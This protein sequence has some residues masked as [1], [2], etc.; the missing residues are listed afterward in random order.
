M[1][2]QTGFERSLKRKKTIVIDEKTPLL[3]L[4]GPIFFELFLNVL[5]NNIDTLMLSHYNEYAVGAVGN[6]NNIMFM[7]NI[8]FNV[9]ATATSVVVAQ[10]L[11]AKKFHKMNMIYTLAFVVNLVFGVTLSGLFCLSNPLI[12]GF[13]NVS[14]EMRP[15]AMTYIYIVGG[16]GFLIAVYSVM[17]QI[18]RC[19][20]YPKIGMWITLA[21]NVVNIGGNYL[22]LYGPLAYLDMGVAGVAISTVA[23]RFIAVIAVFIFFY[24]AKIGKISFRLLRPF[25]KKLLFKMVK[26]GLPTAGE[27][28]TY[29]LY[30]TTMLSFINTMGN[31]SVNARTYCNTLIAFA[32]I[33]SNA[34][35]MATQIIT[36][37]LVGA[38]KSEEA[39]KR[40]FKTLQT[41]LPITIALASTNALICRY[42]LQLF[43]DNQNIIA[44]GQMIMLVD[45]FVEIGRCLNMTFV[46]SLKAAGAYIFP[47]LMGL[48]CNWGLGLSTGYIVGVAL[49]VGVAGIFVGTATDECI[50][51]LIV[52]YYWYKKKWFG[53]SVVDKKE[54]ID[55]D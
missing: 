19:N 50:R 42:T 52:M 8:F 17:L 11:G 4:A 54:T 12:M 31:D 30:Q 7:M 55:Y 24:A 38:G 29:N 39:Y 37:H 16:G 23:A 25:P 10:Y 5:V 36:G 48:L 28:L 18:L 14:S 22:F 40:V 43:T 53:K 20:G 49:G 33:F 41:S 35:A 34:S 13:L 2:E 32:A 47:L 44:L 45:I 26:I 15:Y 21:I 3:I 9:I 1:K 6:A 27:N 51:G 46:C